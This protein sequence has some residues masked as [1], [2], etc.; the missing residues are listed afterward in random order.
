MLG[1]KSDLPGRDYEGQSGAVRRETAWLR[2]RGK[3]EV[4][5]DLQVFYR[6]GHDCVHR[7]LSCDLLC[8]VVTCLRSSAGMRVNP[9]TESAASRDRFPAPPTGKKDVFDIS[10]YK[11]SWLI[12]MSDMAVHRF[13]VSGQCG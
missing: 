11:Y 9:F 2:D 12:G 13:L 6:L 8:C 3:S 4:A 1:P 5:C 7:V 10:Y